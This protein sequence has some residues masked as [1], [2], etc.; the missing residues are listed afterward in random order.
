MGRKSQYSEAYKLET[1]A[2]AEVTDTTYP[3]LK[4]LP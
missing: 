3:V 4:Q 1:V 2:K